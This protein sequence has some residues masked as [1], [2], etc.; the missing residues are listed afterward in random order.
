MKGYT[1]PEGYKGWLPWARRY[2]PFATYT[3][4]KDF[5]N[6]HYEE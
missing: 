1:V 5:Y 3:D 4:Y 6:A 2:Q